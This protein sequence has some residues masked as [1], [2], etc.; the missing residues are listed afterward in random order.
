M[1][2]AREVAARFAATLNMDAHR[3]TKARVRADMLKAIREANDKEFPP[4]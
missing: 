2:T 4:A 1:A 3:G